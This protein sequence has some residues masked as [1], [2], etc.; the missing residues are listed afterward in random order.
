MRGRRHE[1]ERVVHVDFDYSI[2]SILMLNDL[3]KAQS[4]FASC[5]HA[6]KA[7][8]NCKDLASS[9]CSRPS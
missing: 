8:F 1:K 5:R 9:S 7:V 6:Y 3:T 4:A 2:R